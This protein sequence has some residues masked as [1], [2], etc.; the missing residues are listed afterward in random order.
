[1][2]KG[3]E[4]EVNSVDKLGGEQGKAAPKRGG[5]KGANEKC[6]V[7]AEE[8]CEDEE[9]Y[10]EDGISSMIKAQEDIKGR[11][12]RRSRRTERS[13]GRGGSGSGSTLADE[14]AEKAELLNH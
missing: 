7:V 5:T 10:E 6:P 1:M 13:Q 14:T 4:N 9:E 12:R 11:R 8:E 2:P 3:K